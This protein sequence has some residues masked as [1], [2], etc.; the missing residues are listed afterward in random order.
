M[1]PMILAGGLNHRRVETKRRSSQGWRSVVFG[2]GRGKERGKERERRLR[3]RNE[4]KR[5][6]GERKK[7]QKQIV[8]FPSSFSY[9]SCPLLRLRL[10]RQ[11]TCVGLR[12]Q[13]RRRGEQ[14]LIGFV[15]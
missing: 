12:S 8:L 10:A 15:L 14:R 3:E 9:L 11:L 5:V 1:F 4:T 6:G 7:K 13:T 2:G